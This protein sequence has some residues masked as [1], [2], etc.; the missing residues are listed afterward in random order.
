MSNIALILAGGSGARMHQD[1]PKQFL[2]INER[3]IIIYTLETFQRHPEIDSISVVCLDGWENVLKA[4]AEQ[5]NITKLEF[6]IKGGDTGQASIRNGVYELAKHYDDD[7]LVLIHDGIRPMVS[8][9]IISD[10]IVTTRKYGCAHPVSPCTSAMIETKD[11]LTANSHYPR[12]N[13]KIG[14]SPVGFRLK[15]ICDVQR[16]ALEVGITNS[17]GPGILMM[18]LGETIHLCMGS[19]KN[20]KITTVEDIEIFKA[21][22]MS[23]KTDWLK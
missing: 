20:I 22:L 3:P 8:A 23:K 14:Q 16:R 10:C 15:K 7:D 4:Y 19:E 17:I 13:I 1:I 9:E 21:L 12:D 5:F 2:T 11:G 6:V 18:E